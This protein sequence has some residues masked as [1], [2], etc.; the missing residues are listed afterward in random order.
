[1]LIECG[2]TIKEIKQSIGYDVDKLVGCI[3]THEHNDHSQ[4]LKDLLRC[5]IDVYASA[6]TFEA[7]GL[8]GI[9]KT[10]SVT[11][12][13]S[14]QVG[15]FKVMPFD[16]KHDAKQPV[17]YLIEHVDCGKVLFLTDTYY[18]K[19]TFKGLNNIII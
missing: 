8:L 6:G 11:P 9:R 15:G 17:G 10:N 3:V 12:M 18:C 16:V 4:S 7:L 13:K 1:L 5:G 19:Y 14:F 2:V